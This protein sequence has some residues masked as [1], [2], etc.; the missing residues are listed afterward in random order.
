[1]GFPAVGQVVSE[2][3][4]VS[5]LGAAL[6][7][8]NT[9]PT[10]SPQVPALR[11]PQLTMSGRSCLTEQREPFRHLLLSHPFFTWEGQVPACDILFCFCPAPKTGLPII[12]AASLAG[13]LPGAC[14][15]PQVSSLP[16]GWALTG[17]PLRVTGDHGSQHRPGP[18]PHPHAL[19]R[20]G[21]LLH[22]PNKPHHQ[23][24]QVRPAGEALR[25]H[26][27]QL[28]PA[29]GAFTQSGA[30]SCLRLPCSSLAGLGALRKGQRNGPTPVL[31]C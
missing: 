24:H 6:R 11:S 1:M 14:R 20:S 23:P 27:L 17:L 4:G 26:T 13:D 15:G 16:L 3:G 22:S 25:P 19:H 29:W 28:C 12:S 7:S 10:R 31:N 5:V 9:S 30:C 21:R 8:P 2:Q 18:A